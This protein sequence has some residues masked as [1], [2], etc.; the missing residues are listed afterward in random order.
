MGCRKIFAVTTMLLIGAGFAR[1]AGA[2]VA[3]TTQPSTESSDLSV[4]ESP[5]DVGAAPE[6]DLFKDMPIVV[7]A[8]KHPQ[9]IQQAPASASVVSD[10]DIELFGY[11]NLADVLRNQRS[12]YLETDGLNWFAGVRGF[13]RSGEW[14][15]RLL[16]T[17]DDRPTNEL[18]FGQSHLDTDFVVPMEA[19][20]QVEIIRG[21]GSALYGTNAVFGVVNVVTKSGADVN[22]VQV[23]GM[24]GTLGTGQGNILI[25]T[26]LGGWDILADFNGYASAGSN[27]IH[28]DGVNTQQ[29]NFGN[30][31]H[32]DAENAMEG[33]F[34][35]QK[36]EF[37]FEADAE[38]RLKDDSAATYLSSFYDPG[39]MYESRANA[40]ARFDH[41]MGD[42]QSLHG[43]AY[44]GYYGYWQQYP[45]ATT[46]SGLPTY[47]YTST[48]Y[49]S[50]LGQDIHYN[51]DI[52]SQLHLLAGADGTESLYVRQ[53]D[54]DSTQG[55]VL[56]I[57]GSYAQW[58][59]FGQLEYDPTEQLSFT[60]GLRLD[61][62]QRIGYSVSPRLAAVYSPEKYD[63]FKALYGRA[64][65]EPNL[66]EL[67][68]DSPGANTPNPALEPEIIDTFEAVWE[69]NYGDNWRTSFDGYYWEM[70]DALENVQLG[71]GS[72]QTQNGGT[73]TANGVEAEVDKTWDKRASFRAY[74][75]Y[76]WADED[77]D[78]P[79]ESPKWIVGTA[80]AVPVVSRNTYLA[81]EPQ[82][83]GPM[84]NPDNTYTNPTFITNIVLT[85]DDLLK[86]FTFQAG[87]YNLFAHNARLPAGGPQEQV[88]PTITYPATEARVS[89]TY[90]F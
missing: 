66:Y 52:N 31:D 60:G 30:I 58:A 8:T 38:Q 83:V 63:T 79:E 4:G 20:K 17:V 69:R 32:A 73:E 10:S 23:T 72:I 12:F 25:G 14:N 57:P 80:L 67:Q 55:S 34:K 33:F 77:G 3:P 39:E 36:G 2:Q 24:G 13:S 90:R 27:Q 49:D 48:A 21:P 50:W 64:F 76:T 56:N 65:R 9:T 1:S 86:N 22:G 7:A 51:A 19:M 46:S 82:V 78:I 43:M 42:G 11:Q 62:V 75:T 74:A 61:D 87:V 70:H 18:I 47:N 85:S 88:Q 16:V 37:T 81:L 6:L 68:Y 26:T 15:S 84:K 28:Y 53:H 5:N 44:F 29:F 40:M 54:Y 89:V 35:A 71:D 41:D 45:T 59:L